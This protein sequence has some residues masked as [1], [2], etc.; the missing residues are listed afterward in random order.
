MSRGA[1][2]LRIIFDKVD[3]YIRNYDRTKYLKVIHSNEKYG[4]I[5]DR[6]R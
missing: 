5:F 6:I 2:L 3:R 1:N 4:K